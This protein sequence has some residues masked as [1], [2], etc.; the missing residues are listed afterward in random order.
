MHFSL[1]LYD[2]HLTWTDV[3]KYLVK[4]KPATK[5]LYLKLVSTLY[6]TTESLTAPKLQQMQTTNLR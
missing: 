2:C 6:E 5:A 4:I 1:S 3:K